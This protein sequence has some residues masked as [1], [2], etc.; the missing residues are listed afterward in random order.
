[1]APEEATPGFTPPPSPERPPR[2]HSANAEPLPWQDARPPSSLPGERNSWLYRGHLASRAQQDWQSHPGLGSRFCEL[3]SLLRDAPPVPPSGLA[4][5]LL[6]VTECEDVRGSCARLMT[7]T[8]APPRKIERRRQPLPPCPTPRCPYRRA[9]ALHGPRW[10][11]HSG[12]A[13]SIFR[14]LRGCDRSWGRTGSSGRCPARAPTAA[15]R[16]PH[17]PPAA[18][19]AV[20]TAALQHASQGVPTCP[21][22]CSDAAATAGRMIRWSPQRMIPNSILKR[23]TG[24]RILAW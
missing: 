18:V 2:M 21:A 16:P 11:S 19:A 10:I 12:S 1:M 9:T 23:Q 24:P 4:Q 17:P 22:G 3:V 14:I 20:P 7:L 8:G 15:R 6:A 5:T 13:S